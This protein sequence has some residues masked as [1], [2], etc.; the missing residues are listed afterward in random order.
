MVFQ[1]QPVDHGKTN[2]NGSPRD[3]RM[4]KSKGDE[5]GSVGQNEKFAKTVDR[6]K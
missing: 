2:R 4:E 5:P 6:S 3:G 1:E